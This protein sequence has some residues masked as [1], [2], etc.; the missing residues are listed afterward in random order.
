MSVTNCVK[1]IAFRNEKP[2]AFCN[3][4]LS[5]FG[6]C[7]KVSCQFQFFCFGVTANTHVTNLTKSPIMEKVWSAL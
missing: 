3:K 2:D 1:A 7:R 6:N 5:H 4:F